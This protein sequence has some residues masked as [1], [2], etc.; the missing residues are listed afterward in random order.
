MLGIGTADLLWFVA[1]STVLLGSFSH[2]LG[3]Y[4]K[5]APYPRELLACMVALGTNMGLSKMAEVSG[6]SFSSLQGTGAE[7]FLGARLRRGGLDY[8]AGEIR[9]LLA[10]GED[11][12]CSAPAGR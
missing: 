6:L 5:D 7:V 10:E 9:C 1:G 2:V 8:Q 3:R 4:A 11:W 12:A